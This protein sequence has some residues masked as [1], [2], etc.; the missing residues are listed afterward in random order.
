MTWPLSN[1]FHNRMHHLENRESIVKLIRAHYKQKFRLEGR[2]RYCGDQL[3]LSSPEK[4]AAGARLLYIRI[5]F[6]LACLPAYL[7]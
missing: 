4:E 6:I 1:V 2:C 7:R 3:F 5:D